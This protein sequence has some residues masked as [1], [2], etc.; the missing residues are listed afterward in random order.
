[1]QDISTSLEALVQRI[2]SDR[3]KQVRL[4]TTGLDQVPGDYRK[5]LRDIVIQLVRNAVVHGVETP[6]TRRHL[7]KDETGVL[8]VQ[9]QS[10]EHGFE[11]VFQDDGGGIVAERV[12]DAAV[13]RGTITAEEAQ[14]LD[15]KSTLSLVF[16]S[17]FSTYDGADRDA[18][19][20][21]GLDFVL[22]CVQS[23]G[24]KVGM[25]TAPGKYTRF[26][27]TLPAETVQQGAV[28]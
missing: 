20:G 9:F 1:V 7:G 22:K 14:A 19:R 16:R 13:R 3:G 17:G 26:S 4:V 28:A 11:L 6:D 23:L 24:G 15:T 12:R 27:I 2:A 25:A 21:V 10:R 8:Q 18:G 5:A